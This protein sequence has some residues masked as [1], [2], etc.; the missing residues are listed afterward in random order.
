MK[1]FSA[2]VFSLFALLFIG[3]KEDKPTC[4]NCEDENIAGEYSPRAYTT[5]AP[6]YLGQPIIPDD[7]PLTEQGIALGRALFF[8]P[9]LSADSTM[10]CASCHF[11]NL[12]FTDGLAKSVGIQGIPTRRGSMSLTNLVYLRRDFFWDGAAASL[13][14]QALLPIEAH[15]ELNDTWENVEA[16][17]RRHPDYPGLFRAA[18]GI[19]KKSELTKELA[20]KAIAQFERTLVSYNSK[21]D[22]VVWRNQGE[23][24]EEEQLGKE[25]FEV[26]TAI[27]IGHPGCTH[28]H[29][30]PNF[31][32]NNFHNNGLDDVPNL[33]AFADKGRGG[34][35]GVIYDN[36]KFRTPSLRNIA[37]SAPYMHD[38]RFQTLEEVLDHYAAG[39]HGVENENVNI[40]P[41]DLSAEEKR[42]LIA[43]LHTLTDTSFVQNP[44]F[45][46]PF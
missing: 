20:V 40:R 10:T 29:S 11:Q 15:D 14:D 9:I 1:R 16:K 12:N 43:F 44:A 37:L 41:F 30:G 31:T 42:A 23:F 13:E 25:L 39:G 27:S 3:C 45:G 33:N 19:D 22:Q 35:T 21:F 24:T 46:S 36:G 17:L 28:C 18:F 6:A 32:D 34:V 7:N 4:D 5:S 26:E 8:D 38:G 2:V